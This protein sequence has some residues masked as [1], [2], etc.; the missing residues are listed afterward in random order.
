MTGFNN[1]LVPDLLQQEHADHARAM[2][3]LSSCSYPS[4]GSAPGAWREELVSKWAVYTLISEMPL[5]YRTE[6]EHEKLEQFA[7]KLCEAL[8]RMVPNVGGEARF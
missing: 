5:G 2:K 8:I 1:N 4:A 3:A 6:G 7:D